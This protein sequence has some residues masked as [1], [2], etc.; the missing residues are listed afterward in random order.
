MTGAGP[1]GAQTRGFGLILRAESGRYFRTQFVKRL[2]SHE[3]G[4]VIAWL[5]IERGSNVTVGSNPT[6]SAKRDVMTFRPDENAASVRARQR[7]LRPSR[8]LE[9]ASKRNNPL[10]PPL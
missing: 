3:I 4:L 6:P 10:L 5:E 2:D 1:G 8:I 9:L 7:R